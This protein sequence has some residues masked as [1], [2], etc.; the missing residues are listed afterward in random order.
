MTRQWERFSVL[1][2]AGYL[3]LSAALLVLIPVER[4]V[5]ILPLAAVFAVALSHYWA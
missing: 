3:A 2:A 4:V 1:T 5:W